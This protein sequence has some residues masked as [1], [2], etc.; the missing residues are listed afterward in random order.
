M[1]RRCAG[2]DTPDETR[3]GRCP[4][5]DVSH[6]TLELAPDG[7]FT[8][9]PD[10][11]SVEEDVFTY[12]ACIEGG[13]CSEE[14]AT[15][16]IT[17][18][19]VNDEPNAVDDEYETPMGK[20]LEVPAPGVLENDIDPDQGDEQTVEVKDAPLHGVLV[21]NPDGSFTYEPAA[22]F[23]GIDT[24]TYWLTSEPGVQSAYLD[25]ATVRITVRP[26][27]RIFLPIIL[28]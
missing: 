15:V 11:N 12:K 2:D 20:K 1:P 7:S 18:E 27:A 13:E 25:S 23:H 22:G 9:L 26:V 4:C 19:P 6:G 3:I 17:V 28:K 16:T 10:E 14:P 21:L 5:D 24:F 8:Y